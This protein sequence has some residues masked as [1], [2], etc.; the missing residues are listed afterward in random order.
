MQHVRT[1]RAA[2]SGRKARGQGR[3]RPFGSIA[4]AATAAACRSSRSPGRRRPFKTNGERIRFETTNGT[5]ISL[6]RRVRVLRFEFCI[7]NPFETRQTGRRPKVA[8][9]PETAFAGIPWP[10][11]ENLFHFHARKAHVRPSFSSPRHTCV[12]LFPFGCPSRMYGMARILSWRAWGGERVS[13]RMKRGRTV[14]I[15]TWLIVFNYI[16]IIM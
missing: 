6:E 15:L 8:S 2:V 16:R 13:K 11:D 5:L 1:R 4:A 9:E 3:P 7:R 12:L 14:D 10:F